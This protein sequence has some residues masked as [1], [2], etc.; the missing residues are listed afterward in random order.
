MERRGF[1]CFVTVM[2]I[3]PALTIIWVS[4]PFDMSES[5][6]CILRFNLKIETLIWGSAD[7]KPSIYYHIIDVRKTSILFYYIID[8]RKTCEVRFKSG[9]NLGFSI[10]YFKGQQIVNLKLQAII[11]AKSSKY[12]LW[13]E[14]VNFFFVI[15]FYSIYL[16]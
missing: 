1:P 4:Y 13:N 3:W 11:S 9:R 15:I 16:K 14:N 10:S 2:L 7:C 8:V 12:Q 5:Y 6:L